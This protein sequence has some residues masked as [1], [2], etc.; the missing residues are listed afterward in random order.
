MM[1]SFP[2]VLTNPGGGARLWTLAARAGDENTEDAHVERTVKAVES[3]ESFIVVGDCG[4]GR[5][6]RSWSYT[7]R[8]LWVADNSQP[9]RAA[10]NDDCNGGEREEGGPTN[11]GW[12]LS[13]GE[14]YGGTNAPYMPRRPRAEPHTFFLEDARLHSRGESSSRLWLGWWLVEVRDWLLF[15]WE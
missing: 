1:K 12:C 2:E 5:R 8:K 10:D 9:K 4:E 15:T 3:K 6:I 11:W 7:G 14:D 13:E